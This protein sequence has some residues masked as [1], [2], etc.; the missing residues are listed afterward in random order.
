MEAE[1]GRGGERRKV[2]EEKCRIL[3]PWRPR[4]TEEEKGEKKMRKNVQ[5]CRRA[6]P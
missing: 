5:N 6:N 3:I 1:E 2:D 4:K